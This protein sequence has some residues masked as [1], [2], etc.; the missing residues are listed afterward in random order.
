MEC[1]AFRRGDP[2]PKSAKA[3]P[4]PSESG[5]LPSGWD[6]AQSLWA[7]PLAALVGKPPETPLGREEP[8]K[9]RGHFTVGAETG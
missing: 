3:G 9:E 5:S 7:V 1:G 4:P 2:L 6:G 8:R